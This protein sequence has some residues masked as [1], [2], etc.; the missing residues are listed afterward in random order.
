MLRSI[1][2]HL[3]NSRNGATCFP[4]HPAAARMGIPPQPGLR[5]TEGHGQP[6]LVRIFANVRFPAGR[7]AE[8]GRRLWSIRANRGMPCG[9]QAL[10]W[11]TPQETAEHRPKPSMRPSRKRCDRELSEREEIRRGRQAPPLDAFVVFLERS[12]RHMLAKGS[13]MPT[14]GRDRSRPALPYA[15][16]K[17]ESCWSPL[18]QSLAP[19][20]YSTGF[21]LLQ[22]ETEFSEKS[23]I[24]ACNSTS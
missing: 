16:S 10:W 23:R 2:Y 19:D 7:A 14:P 21:H 15:L 6:N 20:S 4:M 9:L 12:S 24:P 3:L 17:H 18:E 1:R 8:L 13:R 11:R 5:P 22:R